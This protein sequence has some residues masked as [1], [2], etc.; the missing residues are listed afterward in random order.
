MCWPLLLEFRY[1]YYPYLQLYMKSIYYEVHAYFLYQ[2]VSFLFFRKNW[3]WLLSTL[4]L[5]WL[6][7]FLWYF[8]L[9]CKSLRLPMMTGCGWAI[10]ANCVY[11]F[12]WIKAVWIG[13]LYIPQFYVDSVAC[14]HIFGVRCCDYGT[15]KH[16]F[17]IPWSCQTDDDVPYYPWASLLWPSLLGRL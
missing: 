5:F 15:E 1:L 4:S 10:L 14:L 7:L 6:I 11:A 9:H 2:P 3:K 8:L 13:I 17:F 12:K 16:H